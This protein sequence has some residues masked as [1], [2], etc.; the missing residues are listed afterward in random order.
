MSARKDP[1]CGMDVREDAV[2]RHTHAGVEY[3]FCNPRCRE[4]FMADPD[5]YL[6]DDIQQP[7]PAPGTKYTCPMD[8]EIVQDGPGDCPIC[9]MALEPMTPTAGAEANAELDDMTRR[10]WIAAALTLPVF[11]LAMA[12]LVPSSARPSWVDGPASH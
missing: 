8:P 3:L 12:H 9:G 5:R 10:L 7:P 11:V 2:L 6:S 1:V 4:K